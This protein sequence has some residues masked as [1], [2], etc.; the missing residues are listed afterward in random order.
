[1]S[2]DDKSIS[3]A[4]PSEARV[5]E[6]Q[7]PTADEIARIIWDERERWNGQPAKT[8]A[9]T[10]GFKAAARIAELYAL[11]SVALALPS[12]TEWKPP[13]TIAL[14]KAEIQSGMDRVKWAEGLIQQLPLNHDGRNSWLMN[15]GRGEEAAQI[16]AGRNSKRNA[17]G[18]PPL[19]HR[20][21]GEKSSNKHTPEAPPP[22]T[23]YPELQ[24]CRVCG[25]IA[26]AFTC[27]RNDCP[28]P[29]G[30]K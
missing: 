29:E 1:M 8:T 24:T 4:A 11:R 13:H 6:A 12:S 17:L 28:T 27:T 3:T 19:P 25:V 20:P 9:E 15:Y 26:H 30:E 10:W 18:L 7:Q 5:S 22:T 2:K 21:E 23:P 16:R 14:D